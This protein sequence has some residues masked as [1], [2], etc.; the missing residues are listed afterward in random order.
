MCSSTIYCKISVC[1]CICI[2]S[3]ALPS[4]HVFKMNKE[5]ELVP[6]KYSKATAPPLP[7]TPGC[8]VLFQYGSDFMVD[9]MALHI[10]QSHKLYIIT[11][12][13]YLMHHHIRTGAYRADPHDYECGAYN[14]YCLYMSNLVDGLL[15]IDIIII[16][17]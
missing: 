17:I 11:V 3:F 14:G 1:A 5:R 8:S 12:T 2:Y 13:L 6:N 16:C 7:H 15:E 10:I 9:C 4:L